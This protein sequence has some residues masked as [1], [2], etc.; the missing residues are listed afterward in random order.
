M[1]LVILVPTWASPA[2]GV[3]CHHGG[4]TW[5]C[6]LCSTPGPQVHLLT[7]VL[8]WA[9]L[10]PGDC[11]PQLDLTWT[12]SLWSPSGSH[13]ALVTVNPTLV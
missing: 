1:Y 2:R 10:G 8:N 9:K 13:R 6:L 7:M 11:V 3:S 12:R 5:T 4:L